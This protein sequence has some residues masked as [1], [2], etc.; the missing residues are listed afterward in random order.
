[1]K[2]KDISAMKRKAVMKRWSAPGARAA[3]AKRMKAQGGIR[4]NLIAL[5]G[6][7]YF[8]RIQRGEKPSVDK[9]KKRI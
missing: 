4:E 7:D 3:W 9:V 8:S 5:Y 2:K 6:H 1:M